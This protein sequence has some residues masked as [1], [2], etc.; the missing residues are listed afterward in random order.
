MSSAAIWL[1]CSKS[2]TVLFYP[3]PPACFKRQSSYCL[4]C[5]DLGLFPLLAV[6]P[7]GQQGCAQKSTGEDTWGPEGQALR[8][9][10]IPTA[11]CPYQLGCMQTGSDGLGPG[12]EPLSCKF[13]CSVYGR[14]I[15][16][17]LLLEEPSA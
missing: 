12:W 2:C 9:H 6:H 8:A 11:W 5:F 16:P 1:N 4:L 15:G 13:R 3:N 17:M 14:S 10:C 7:P